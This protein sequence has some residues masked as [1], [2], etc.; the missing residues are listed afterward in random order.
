MCLWAWVPEGCQI[1]V[2]DD[3]KR[4]RNLLRVSM[5]AFLGGALMVLP[6]TS[7]GVLADWPAGAIFP[8]TVFIL[9]LRMVQ[10]LKWYQLKSVEDLKT[11][12]KEQKL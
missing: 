7:C 10:D 2:A 6:A 1:G 9:Q 12:E 8:A 4:L 11:V 3:F 5:S